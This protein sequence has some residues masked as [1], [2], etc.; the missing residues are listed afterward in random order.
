MPNSAQRAREVWVKT[1]IRHNPSQ[2]VGARHPQR[3][4]PRADQAHQPPG[5]TLQVRIIVRNGSL[6]APTA[7]EASIVVA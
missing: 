1:K 2:R 3:L 7:P 4:R 5:A 6:E